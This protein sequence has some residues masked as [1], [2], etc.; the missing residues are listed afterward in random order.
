MSS[1]QLELKPLNEA[2]AEKQPE[3]PL[4]PAQRAHGT[5]LN[6]VACRLR[7]IREDD[8]SAKAI[9]F[10]QWTDLEAQVEKAL[11]AHGIPTLR[12]HTRAKKSPSAV[13]KE[14]QEDADS[15]YVLILSLEQAA[16]GTNLT[17]AN[18]VLFVHPMN[19][20]TVSTAVAWEKQAIGRVRR[21]G[22]KRSEIHV[23]RFVAR[24]TVEEHITRVHQEH[25]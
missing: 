8:A 12:Y 6:A 23:Y 10:V 1:L 20:E 21:I 11:Q 15:P 22:Q 3:V 18:H 13:L 4:T 24:D 19:A 17:A 16:A 5:K 9:V 2:T 7:Q 14:F 25:S